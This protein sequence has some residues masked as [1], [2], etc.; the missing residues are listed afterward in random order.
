LLVARVQANVPG[1]IYA[2]EL[3]RFPR[4][5]L[6]PAKLKVDDSARVPG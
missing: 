6:L 1:E 2:F 3:V 5:E 4:A